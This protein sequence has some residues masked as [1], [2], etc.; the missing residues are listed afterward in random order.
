MLGGKS[1]KKYREK[2]SWKNHEKNSK[3][4]MKKFEKILIF[5]LQK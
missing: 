5:I 1:W 4:I 3:I 2:Y